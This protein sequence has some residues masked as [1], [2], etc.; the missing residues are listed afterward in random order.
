MAISGTPWRLST[1][2]TRASS[3]LSPL[4][5]MASTTSCCVTMPKSPCPASAGCTNMAG[6]PVEA[7]VAAILR[8]TCPLLPMPI[9]TTRPCAASM[10]ATAAAICCAACGS[11]RRRAACCKAA[12]SMLNVSCASCKARAVFSGQ[13]GKGGVLVAV[14]PKIVAMPLVCRPMS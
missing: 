13:A 9:I 2:T 4:L 14:M 1:G 10:V 7:S 3:S 11:C 12:A 6:V 5:L 8:P